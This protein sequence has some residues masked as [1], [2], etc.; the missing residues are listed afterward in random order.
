MTQESTQKK[1]DKIL[2]KNGYL[3]LKEVVNNI[4]HCGYYDF[5]IKIKYRYF[6][7]DNIFYNFDYYI[8][9]DDIEVCVL[10]N[11]VIDKINQFLESYGRA[12]KIETDAA[13]R[14]FC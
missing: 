7:D 3:L 12:R 13:A 8:Y 5:T 9:I 1:L 6:T 14:E 10:D 11:N 4:E 2:L